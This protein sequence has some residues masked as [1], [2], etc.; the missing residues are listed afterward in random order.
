ME[1]MSIVSSYSEEASQDLKSAEPEQE[2]Q[3]AHDLLSACTYQTCPVCPPDVSGMT[4]AAEQQAVVCN[5]AQAW[6]R[7]SDESTSVSHDTH[8]LCLMAKKSRKKSNKKDQEKEKA[9]VDDQDESDVEVEDNYNLDHLNRKDK[10]IIIKIVEKNDELEEE[11]KKQEQ[12]LQKQELFLIS[13]MEELKALSERY[14]N[15]QL[16]M[17]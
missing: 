10:F 8:H 15:C 11:I 3:A 2:V 1:S 12:S 9:Q 16:S 14:E 6:W 5:D 7:P 17:L 4:E 13:K